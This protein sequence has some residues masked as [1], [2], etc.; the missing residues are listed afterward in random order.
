M[1][2]QDISNNLNFD[3]GASTSNGSEYFFGGSSGYPLSPMEGAS[4]GFVTRYTNIAQKIQDLARVQATFTRFNQQPDLRFIKESFRVVQKADTLDFLDLASFFHPLQSFS[5]FQKQTFSIGPE[6]TINLDP[7]S[8]DSTLGEASMIMA[9]AYYLPETGADQK[10]LFW[11]YKGQS[12][13][14][15]G[16]FMVLTGAIKDGYNW[17]GWDLDPFSTYGH[18]GGANISNGGISF[19]N[20]TS[21][22][23]K[24]VV[25]TA[26]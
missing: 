2:D 6:N 22:V 10:L 17:H 15:M 18:T 21:S 8:F 9:R 1:A 11:D 3:G 23:V 19:T 16:E 5:G 12:R 13:N 14:T 24:L 25:I 7:G 4:G 26:N 20:P